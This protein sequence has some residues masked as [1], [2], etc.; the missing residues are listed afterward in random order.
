MQ[1][2]DWKDATMH[3]RVIDRGSDKIAF[4]YE[5]NATLG[6]LA[7]LRPNK[8]AAA[9]EIDPAVAAI[10]RK[11]PEPGPAPKPEERKGNSKPAPKK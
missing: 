4:A 8:P 5:D 3:L 7:S 10:T 1:E 9:N 6:N 11:D 2:V